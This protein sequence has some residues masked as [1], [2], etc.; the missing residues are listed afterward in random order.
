MFIR[1]RVKTHK[2]ILEW[3]EEN[4]IT[5]DTW[6]VHTHDGK[7]KV[8]MQIAEAFKIKKKHPDCVIAVVHS[9]L[10][11]GDP[12]QWMHLADESEKKKDSLFLRKL[13]KKRQAKEGQGKPEKKGFKFWS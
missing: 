5:T 7:V 8:G 12:N 1:H 6:T 13:E 4:G 3:A 2:A 11:T 9:S 10:D